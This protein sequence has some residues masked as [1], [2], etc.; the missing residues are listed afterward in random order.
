MEEFN[1]PILEHYENFDMTDFVT[2]NPKIKINCIKFEGLKRTDEKFLL[3]ALERC[4]IEGCCN[5]MELSESLNLAFNKLERLNIFKDISV[6]I[7]QADTLEKD[8]NV[9]DTE[10]IH[11]VKIIFKC[12]EKRLNIRTGTELQRKDIAWVKIIKLIEFLFLFL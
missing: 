5:L 4:G 6:A 11:K 12:K 8:L 7:D 9:F 3:S 10:L 1:E 2:S